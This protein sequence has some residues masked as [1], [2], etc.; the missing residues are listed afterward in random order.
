MS[1]LHVV[2]SDMVLDKASEWSSGPNVFLAGPTPRSSSVLS[3]RPEV[4]DTLRNK[5]FS[6][7]LLVPERSDWTTLKDYSDQTNWEWDAMALSDLILFWV[8]RDMAVM[9]ALTTNVEFG[10]QMGMLFA[11]PE[12]RLTKEVIY[13]RPDNAP[14]VRYLDDLF[15]RVI[16]DRP[17]YSS[18][19]DSLDALVKWAN[20]R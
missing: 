17:V 1:K 10:F 6:G 18:L 2:T 8:P 19:N 14:S 9:P 4:I 7:T 20:K 12:F 5:G 3:W 13:G 11:N 15:K 16:K